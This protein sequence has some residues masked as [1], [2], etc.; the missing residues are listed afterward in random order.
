[1]LICLIGRRQQ[2]LLCS[3]PEGGLEVDALLAQLFA[4]SL[5]RAALLNRLRH[6]LNVRHLGVV[7]LASLRGELDACVA[8]YRIRRVSASSGGWE[9]GAYGTARHGTHTSTVFERGNDLVGELVARVARAQDGN[10]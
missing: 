7:A 8:A 9:S 2:R 4:E 1:L 10:H 5:A 6:V 3:L